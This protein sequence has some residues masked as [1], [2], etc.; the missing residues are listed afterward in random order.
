[1]KRY[2]SLFLILFSLFII[3]STVSFAADCSKS[4]V[5]ITTVGIDLLSDPTG[6]SCPDL[7]STTDNKKILADT[8]ASKV[9]TIV[10]IILGFSATIGLIAFV[11]A[12][13]MILISNGDPKAYQKGMGI[14]K[15]TFGGI[16]IIIFSYAIVSFLTTTIPNVTGNPT[17]NISTDVACTSQAD[18][19]NIAD[20]FCCL[21]SAN[22]SN[23]IDK[24]CNI[25]K[26]GDDCGKSGGSCYRTTDLADITGKIPTGDGFCKDIAGWN[27]YKTDTTTSTNTTTTPTSILGTSF[28]SGV[29][30]GDLCSCSGGTVSSSSCAGRCIY[31]LTSSLASSPVV[32]NTLSSSTCS[33]TSGDTTLICINSATYPLIK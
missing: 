29:S 30:N 6:R 16:L 22:F 8:V 17:P 24:T 15:Y 5:G 21:Y 25:I 18:C 14:I 28:K 7:T 19:N 3:S 26:S 10:K 2:I 20:S 13:V 23:C 12:G 27:C 4:G 31:V 33:G 1:M 11:Y 9:N 32:S